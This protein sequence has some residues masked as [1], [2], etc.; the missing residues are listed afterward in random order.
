MVRAGRFYNLIFGTNAC[1]INLTKDKTEHNVTIN[2]V[3]INILK[4]KF[5]Y[6][7]FMYT[8]KPLTIR[9]CKILE[10]KNIFD[11]DNL[12]FSSSEC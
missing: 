1:N 10:G 3:V 9:N 5:T 8:R 11:T 4:S 6:F 7:S 2:A 12:L